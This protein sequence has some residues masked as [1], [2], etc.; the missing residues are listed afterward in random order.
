VTGYITDT[1]A[2][3]VSAGLFVPLAPTRMFDTRDGAPMAGPVPAGGTIALVHT[4]RAGV[5]ADRV[6][7]LALN[8]TAV[9]AAAAG[10]V[11]AYPTASGRPDTSTLNV[12]AGDVR[13]NAAV[14][15]VDPAGSI[16]YFAQRGAHLV[17]D[18]AGYFT[19]AA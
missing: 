4:G 19:A 9:D 15:K 6:G 7:A 8:V 16:S 5:P 11:T 14:M 2:L 12:V 18:V 3:S 1:S 17:V 13:P 10:F